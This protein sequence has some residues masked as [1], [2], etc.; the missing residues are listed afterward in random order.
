MKKNYIVNFLLMMLFVLNNILFAQNWNVGVP[1]D[2]QLSFLDKSSGFCAPGQPD[3]KINVICNQVDGIQYMILV[4]SLV[5]I[6]VIPIV[7]DT[8]EL[9]DTL[10]LNA[11][12]NN[13][14]FSFI[15]GPG[16]ISLNLKAVGIPITAG[17]NHPCSYTD[18]WSSNLLLCNEEL[19]LDL[20]NT[21][22]VIN[23]SNIY[24]IKNNKANIQFPNLSNQ[25]QMTV[26]GVSNNSLISIS[27]ISGKQIIS[28]FTISNKNAVIPCQE[29]QS[30]IYFVTLIENNIPSTFKFSICK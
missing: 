20:Q 30:G 3:F 22:S 23:T 8:L 5:D 7:N 9:G 28:N 4:D 18:N 16:K 27:D 2:L 10:M 29:L 6:V 15:N 1:V 24:N 14:T 11:G 19:T 21:C 17:Q 13:F 12:N 26:N 25:L